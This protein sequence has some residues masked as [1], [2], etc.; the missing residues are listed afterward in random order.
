MLQCTVGQ[1]KMRVMTLAATDEDCA[2]IFQRW[3]DFAFSD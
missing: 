1:P 3:A 2:S